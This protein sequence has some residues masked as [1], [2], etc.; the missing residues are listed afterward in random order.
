MEGVLSCW[1]EWEGT[2]TTQSDTS[3]RQCWLKRSGVDCTYI[4][5]R[6]VWNVFRCIWPC[7]VVSDIVHYLVSQ[8]RVVFLI[9]SMAELGLRYNVSVRSFCKDCWFAITDLLVSSR[10]S[11]FQRFFFWVPLRVEYVSKKIIIKCKIV[12]KTKITYV[13]PASDGSAHTPYRE[14]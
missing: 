3:S 9:I 1:A 12:S 4:A 10:C 14:R 5:N 11:S 6:D 7:L 8:S 2:T 13:A